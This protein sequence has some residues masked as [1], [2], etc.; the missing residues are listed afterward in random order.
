M[1]PGRPENSASSRD[2]AGSASHRNPQLPQGVPARES[3][4]A[5]VNT[6]PRRRRLMVA[7]RLRERLASVVSVLTT[8]AQYLLAAITYFSQ[9]P[10]NVLAVVLAAATLTM[11]AT[12]WWAFVRADYVA[13]IVRSIAGL[14]GLAFFTA[15]ESRSPGPM[16]T[17]IT[18]CAVR[19]RQS[20]AGA[21]PA[22]QL[23]LQPVAIGA[24][25][26]GNDIRLKHS[27][28]TGR[29]GRLS[30]HTGHNAK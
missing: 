18:M 2:D 26:G 29:L 19:R 24:D 7:L 22:R 27:D 12:A 17:I 20:S 1:T 8:A 3:A 10:G 4:E 21:N 16:V 5:A 14:V 9:Q 11:F 23:S 15:L 28:A 13:A 25:G 30:D 6:P